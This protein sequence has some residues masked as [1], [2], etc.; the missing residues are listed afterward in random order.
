MR[1]SMARSRVP[2]HIQ[3]RLG[4][5]FPTGVECAARGTAMTKKICTLL[6]SLVLMAGMPSAY[7]LSKGSHGKKSSSSKTHK[8]KT[9]DN[10]AGIPC[11]DGTVSHAKNRRGACS[12]HGGVKYARRRAATA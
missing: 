11:R 3:K 5:V 10:S 1:S 8:P 7:G 6:L 2:I 9:T 12:H 4:T